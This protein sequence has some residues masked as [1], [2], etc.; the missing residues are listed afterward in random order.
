[1]QFKTI[2][3]RVENAFCDSDA[4]A[5][6]D[7][8]LDIVLQT[9]RDVA[10]ALRR[11]GIVL[12]LLIAAFLLL[13]GAQES[14]ISVG[15]FQIDDLSA[16]LVLMPALVAHLLYEFVALVIA[17][18]VY[19]QLRLHVVRHL[20]P[21]VE[22]NDL[23]SAIAPGSPSF[24]G[25]DSWRLLRTKPPGLLKPIENGITAAILGAIVI[26]CAGFVVDA[27]VRLPSRPHVNDVELV[28]SALFALFALLRMALL[29]VD[30]WRTT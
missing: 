5:F 27:Y 26:G 3:E 11:T 13:F 2:S 28:L 7:R 24:W 16:V 21:T 23:E 29:V 19:D 9:W 14:T 20:H 12:A 17:F 18:N 30:R 4:K 10:V 1:M 6:G 25:Q 8:Y 15:P 22:S